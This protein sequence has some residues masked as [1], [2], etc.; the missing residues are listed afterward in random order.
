MRGMVGSDA[1]T[2]P[3]PEPAATREFNS[4]RE[5]NAWPAV[6]K[7]VFTPYTDDPEAGRDPVVLLHEQQRL[8]DG[9]CR[10][11]CCVNRSNG[12]VNYRPGHTSGFAFTLDYPS[13]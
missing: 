3:L 6:G 4:P 1:V 11:C 12:G 5:E 10:A 13:A 2:E 8:M 7:Q 9:A